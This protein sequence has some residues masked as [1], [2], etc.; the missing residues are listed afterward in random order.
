M[1][2][3]FFI[4][5]SSLLT[6]LVLT[7]NLTLNVK[8]E[9]NTVVMAS[10]NVFALRMTFNNKTV[11]NEK[12]K[13]KKIRKHNY[14]PILFLEIIKRSEINIKELTLIIP[15]K[16]PHFSAFIVG[17]YDIMASFAVSFFELHSKK[18]SYEKINTVFSEHNVPKVS[19]D[20]GLSISFPELLSCIFIYAAKLTKS[21]IFKRRGV[22][23]GRKQNG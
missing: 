14:L 12:S 10:L 17:G 5:L 22:I 15:S 7:E 8:H 16:T 9:N 20:V 23:Y 4:L 13:P 11:A 21:K 18:I 6:F 3:P 1:L 19:L 2:F